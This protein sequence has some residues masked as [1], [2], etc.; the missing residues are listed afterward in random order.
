MAKKRTSIGAP[1]ALDQAA[2]ETRISFIKSVKLAGIGLDRTDAK[3]DRNLLAIAL[4]RDEEL[5]TE[6]SIR[7]FVIAHEAEYFVVGGEFILKQHSQGSDAEIVSVKAEFSA[8][9]DLSIAANEE[10]VARFAN[11]EARLVLFP[12]MRHFV[13]DISYRMSINPII[14]P[15]TSELERQR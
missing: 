8:R 2:A 12:Y 11:L 7:Q 13:S 15:L 4:Q 6:V 9:F 10:F 1:A 14:L 3:I 5:E